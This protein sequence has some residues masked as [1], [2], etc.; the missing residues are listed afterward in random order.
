MRTWS[1]AGC[2]AEDDVVQSGVV[3][4]R[5]P[6]GRP[7][8]DWRLRVN[9]TSLECCV[10]GQLAAQG[11]AATGNF[12]GLSGQR[13]FQ[14]ELLGSFKS[15][16][17]WRAW[18]TPTYRIPTSAGVG[19]GLLVLGVVC[20]CALAVVWYRRKRAADALA[21]ELKG[22]V[23][24]L[25]SQISEM[26]VAAE[27]ASM[28]E[29]MQARDTFATKLNAM[30]KSRLCAPGEYDSTLRALISKVR[31]PPDPANAPLP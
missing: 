18:Q 17:A 10:E 26:Q 3:T 24:D 20:A 28:K 9:P 5:D 16:G 15:H 27:P 6:Q 19:I 1:G 22:T 11:A 23:E 8:G 12:P 14:Q 29:I 21:V 30:V 25:Q 2:S 7:L 31:M 4:L 13:S